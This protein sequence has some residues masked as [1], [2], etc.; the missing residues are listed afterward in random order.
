MGQWVIDTMGQ[1]T[2]ES[3]IQWVKLEGFGVVVTS[4]PFA[5][6]RRK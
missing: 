5:Q 2:I 4:V 6:A 1:L 3:M